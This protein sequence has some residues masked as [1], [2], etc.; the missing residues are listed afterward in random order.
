[1]FFR[2]AGF[3]T[4]SLK[5]FGAATSTGPWGSRAARRFWGFMR[6][7]K[8]TSG[9]RFFYAAFAVAALSR[10]WSFSSGFLSTRFFACTFGI[11]AICR[12]I[13]SGKSAL[14]FRSPGFFYR[15]PPVTFATGCKNFFCA[16]RYA[17]TP[18]KNAA[19]FSNQPS[20][21]LPS[22]RPIPWPPV[23]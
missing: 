6:S 5:S 1:M 16:G 21:S 7:M 12:L 9:C 4:A 15:S 18:C 3:F 19:A 14:C 8:N 2:S 23:S 22:A 10:R 20:A 17:K 11:T 13:F